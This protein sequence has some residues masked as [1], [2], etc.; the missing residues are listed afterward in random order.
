VSDGL[1]TTPARSPLR[2]TAVL[3]A[4]AFFLLLLFTWNTAPAAAIT[5]GQ[6]LGY[7]FARTLSLTIGAF[8]ALAGAAIVTATARAPRWGADPFPLVLV[9]QILLLTLIYTVLVFGVD[10]LARRAVDRRLFL[11]EIAR[12]AFLTAIQ[13]EPAGDPEVALALAATVLLVNPNHAGGR[14]LHRRLQSQIPSAGRDTEGADLFDDVLQLEELGPTQLA[15]LAARFL[16]LHDP[17][18]GYHFA[19]LAIQIEPQVE[20]NTRALALRDQAI[21][22]IGSAGL[23]PEEIA[24]QSRFRRKQYATDADAIDAYY[25]WLELAADDPVD[26]DVQDRLPRAASLVQQ[27]TYWRARAEIS[28]LL[29]G[30]EE[31]VFINKRYADGAAREVVRIGRLVQLGAATYGQ[32]VEVV[33]FGSSGE[34]TLH[35]LAP[36]AQLRGPQL[37][38][39]GIERLRRAP[40]VVPRVLIGGDFDAANSVIAINLSV[41]ELYRLREPLVARTG[42][43]ELRTAMELAAAA[44]HTT[45]EVTTALGRAASRPLYTLGLMLAAAVLGAWGRRMRPNSGNGVELT[46]LPA[47]VAAIALVSA[48]LWDGQR[49]L[50]DALVL[51]LGL[52]AGTGITL[53]LQLLL[54]ATALGLVAAAHRR[55]VARPPGRPPGGGG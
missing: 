34:R 54:V 43:G 4:V 40:Q 30:A 3:V 17:Y 21:E 28:Q 20:R 11:G 10:P 52:V 9:R 37:L 36:V 47:L 27:T 39:V 48:L 42:L 46:L 51:A 6:L 32:D 38:M 25:T 49:L 1:A 2:L 29:P 55:A 35:M 19:D 50:A 12:T 53:G 26:P 31:L 14:E 45:T 44:G 5:G 18:S 22:Q 23:A 41:D 8:P 13:Q 15:D 16:G 24:A 33:R 7:L